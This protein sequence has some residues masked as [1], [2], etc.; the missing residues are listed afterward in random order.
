MRATVPQHF[1]IVTDA[2]FG[3]STSLVFRITAVLWCFDTDS[4]V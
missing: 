4:A 2:T 3:K 1:V